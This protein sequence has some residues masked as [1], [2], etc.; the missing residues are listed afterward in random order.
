MVIRGRSPLTAVLARFDTIF[1]LL[2]YLMVQCLA[3]YMSAALPSA[4]AATLVTGDN[5]HI[6]IDNDIFIA[7]CGTAI[8][9]VKTPESFASV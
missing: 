3:A 7:T 9:V 4:S 1:L 2:P 5:D 8:L 6:I